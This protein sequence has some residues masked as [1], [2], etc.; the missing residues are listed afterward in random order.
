M[1]YL[2]IN[3]TAIHVERAFHVRQNVGTHRWRMYLSLLEEVAY[4]LAVAG[5]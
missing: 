1:T 4:N 5:F 2:G 3:I